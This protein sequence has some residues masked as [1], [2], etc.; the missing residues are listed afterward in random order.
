MSERVLV[1]KSIIPMSLS[2]DV[3]PIPLG[4]YLVHTKHLR[5]V[6]GNLRRQE[7]SSWAKCSLHQWQSCFRDKRAQGH[8]HLVHGLLLVY[9][10]TPQKAGDKTVGYKDN[11]QVG[12]M[13]SADGKKKVNTIVK[14]ESHNFVVNQ[15]NISNWLK[16]LVPG[17]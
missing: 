7:E 6:V 15:R 12:E 1:W 11:L 10:D 3:I 5:K 13:G 9:H 2:H 14:T 8:H 4:L 17:L 16:K